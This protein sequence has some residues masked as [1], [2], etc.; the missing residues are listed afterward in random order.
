MCRHHPSPLGVRCHS[1]L[2]E[3][4]PGWRSSDRFRV[5]RPT[6]RVTSVARIRLPSPDHAC[7]SVPFV[8]EAKNIAIGTEII[9]ERLLTFCSARG[10]V[11][12]FHNPRHRRKAFAQGNLAMLPEHKPVRR[13]REMFDLLA[14]EVP[15]PKPAKIR[16]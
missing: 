15:K 10:V 12:L 6:A 8:C 11:L 3:R 4:H 13:G 1:C 16:A 14:V 2:S 9:D 5:G 7:G